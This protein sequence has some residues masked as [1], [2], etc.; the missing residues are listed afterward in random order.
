MIVLGFSGGSDS[1]AS[2]CNAGNMG[3]IPESGR[4]PGEGH[5]N[6]LQWSCREKSQRQRSL[7]GHSLWGCNKSDMTEATEHTYTATVHPKGGG[8][9]TAAHKKETWTMQVT[10]HHRD[11]L[12]ILVPSLVLSNTAKATWLSSLSTRRARGT[13]R[14][15]TRRRGSGEWS[16]VEFAVEC[17]AVKTSGGHCS[18]GLWFPRW[19]V[20]CL[21]VGAMDSVVLWMGAVFTNHVGAGIW[22]MSS[23]TRTLNTRI[24]FSLLGI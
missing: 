13:H 18:L 22:W 24:P 7:V 1:K 15:V 8:R 23:K 6:L 11:S 17:P 10:V 2:A 19:S 4:S 12:P 20:L 16:G 3:S 21:E 5:S 14:A 9:K